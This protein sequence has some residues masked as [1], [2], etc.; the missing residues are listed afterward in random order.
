M[1]VS[2]LQCNYCELQDGDDLIFACIFAT[3]ELSDAAQIHELCYGATLRFPYTLTAPSFTKAIY[4]TPEKGGPLSRTVI[5]NE[6]Q[7][8]SRR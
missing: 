2:A 3:G 4:F 7:V 8:R 1:C 5:F 6:G